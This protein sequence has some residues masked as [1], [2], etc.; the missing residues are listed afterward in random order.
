MNEPMNPHAWRQRREDIA[1]EAEQD[2]PAR[3]LRA[4]R[5]RHANRTFSPAWELRRMAGP[6]LKLLWRLESR[7]GGRP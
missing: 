5:K 7:D 3:V 4:E 6:L 2:R 1:R